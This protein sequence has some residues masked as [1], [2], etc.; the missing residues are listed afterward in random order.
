MRLLTTRRALLNSLPA[1]LVSTAPSSNIA[2]SAAYRSASV[3]VAGASVPVALW[4]PPAAAAVDFGAPAADYAYR[5]DLGRIASKLGLGFLGWLPARDCPLPIGQ[6]A[7]THAPRKNCA[8][9]FA[10]GYLGSRFDLQHVCEALAA[11]GFVVAAPELPESLAA[12]FVPNE[13]TTRAAIMAATRALVDGA[14]GPQRYGIV[15]HSA[16][17]GTA[18][19]LAEPC[20]L[21]RAAL[22]GYRGYDGSDP[23][24]VLASSGDSVIPLEYIQNA[25]AA[26]AAAGRPAATTTLDVLDFARRRTAVLL[27]AALPGADAPPNHISFLSEGTNDEMVKF[28]SPFLPLARLLGIPLLDFDAYQLS[29][30]AAPTARAVTPAVLSFFRANA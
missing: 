4:L 25:L 20:P 6:F 7:E 23:L 12:S 16:G 17:A 27:D 10:H 2:M 28:L 29:G 21:G 19:M 11:D 9:L 1:L 13:A 30:D 8:I 15:G 5:I 22:C 26:E 3:E 18:T 24:L 14:L